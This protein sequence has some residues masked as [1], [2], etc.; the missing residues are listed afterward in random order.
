MRGTFQYKSFGAVFFVEIHFNTDS[1]EQEIIEENF[2]SE[3]HHGN[4]VL[5]VGKF[6]VKTSQE[7]TAREEA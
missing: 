6:Q 2:K 3:K 4:V 5:Q 1:Q 7:T